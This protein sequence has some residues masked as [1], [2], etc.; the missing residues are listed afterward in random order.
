MQWTYACIRIGRHCVR[1]VHL[2]LRHPARAWPMPQHA[3]VDEQATKAARG[4]VL[5]NGVAI[6]GWKI[7]SCH[8]PMIG[9]S[10]VE[11]YKAELGGVL[12]IPE[13]VFGNN[14]LSFTHTATGVQLHFSALDALK[15]WREEDLKP[16]QVKGAERWKQ[17]H[18]KE[19]E[20][21]GAVQLEYDWTYTTPYTGSLEAYNSQASCVV[22][23]PSTITAAVP[24]WG[25]ASTDD[26]DMSLL[27]AQDPILFY[28][29]FVL[30]E[31]ELDD[32]GHC[33][34]QIKTRCMP[35]C[36]YVLMSFFLRVDECLVRVRETRLF[37][38]F[39][40]EETQGVVFREI[41]HCEG[42]FDD[43]RA[44]GAPP[45]GPA[46]ATADKASASFQSAAPT[47]L[48]LHKCEKLQI[49]WKR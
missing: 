49:A 30:Y 44:Q 10:E 8:G 21:H 24:Q 20:E 45:E 3:F 46:Y 16:L 23:A 22:D 2:R 25:E 31:S 13:M 43:L 12:T 26:V 17:S 47:G 42:S 27:V 1:S 28:D 38:R 4:E 18:Q 40:C 6:G 41:R 36:W 9:D 35:K 34:L 33:Q 32:C 15:A 37:C 7:E 29:T 48:K 39:D 19:I 11:Q 5:A 14:C